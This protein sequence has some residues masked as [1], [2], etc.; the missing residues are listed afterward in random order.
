MNKYEAMFIIK[1]E[2]PEAERSGL[3]NQIKDVITKKG[4][5]VSQDSIW[6]EKKKLYFVIKKYREGAY[7][8]V[9]FT[10]PP[11][12]VSEIKQAYNINDNILRYL[13]TKQ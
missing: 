13:I 6:A 8:L 11:E 10:L 4:G 3:V 2:L 7:L 1:P 9:N 12:A 5:S